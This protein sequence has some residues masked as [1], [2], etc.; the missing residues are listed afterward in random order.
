MSANTE[1]AYW[2]SVKKLSALGENKSYYQ[3]ELKQY[4]E[5]LASLYERIK[6][7]KADISRTKREIKKLTT[8]E[9]NFHLK[10]HP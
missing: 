6:Y 10:P 8:K 3:N 9:K 2:E 1:L 5:E 4:E 7:L